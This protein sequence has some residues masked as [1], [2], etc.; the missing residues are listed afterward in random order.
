MQRYIRLITAAIVTAIALEAGAAETSLT[1]SA[2]DGEVK[3]IVFDAAKMTV[4]MDGMNMVEVAIF[5]HELRFTHD[6]GVA[7]RWRV[8]IDRTTGRMIIGIPRSSMNLDPLQCEKTSQ[9]F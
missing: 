1:C 3:R 8:S 5:K 7:G 6:L 4:V 2:H 9:K